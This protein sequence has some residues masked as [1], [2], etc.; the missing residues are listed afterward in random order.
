M[1]KELEKIVSMA[2]EEMNFYK[3]K[4]ELEVPKYELL[5]DFYKSFIIKQK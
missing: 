4:E 5:R 2:K 3:M 1:T